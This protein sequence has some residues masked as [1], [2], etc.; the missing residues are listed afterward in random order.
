MQVGYKPPPSPDEVAMT[1]DSMAAML[2]ANGGK[3]MRNM[4]NG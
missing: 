4:R 3:M 2:E 1:S